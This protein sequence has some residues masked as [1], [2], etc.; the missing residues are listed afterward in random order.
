MHIHKV[1][2][3][4]FRLLTKVELLFEEKTTVIVGRNNSGKTSLT[5]LFRR[6]L[7]DST[8]T[9]RLEDFSLSA[10]ESFWAVFMNRLCDNV[11]VE[12]QDKKETDLQIHGDPATVSNWRSP[13]IGRRIWPGY[14]FPAGCFGMAKTRPAMCSPSFR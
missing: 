12:V 11:L 14:H 4:N 7:G 8:P 10:H 2:I 13:H 1:E 9:F 6:L 3:K 5:K